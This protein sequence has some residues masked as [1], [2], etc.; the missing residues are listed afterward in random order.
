MQKNTNMN[1]RRL[2]AR[3]RSGFTLLETLIAT[4]IGALVLAGLMSV[5][6][7]VADRTTYAQHIA[8]SH[9]EALRSSRN[10]IAFLRNADAI[11]AIDTNHWRWVEVRGVNG[12]RTRF[13]H[14]NPIAGQRDGYMYMSNNLGSALVVARGMTEIM[15]PTGFSPSIFRI[16]ATN[17]LRISYRVVEPVMSQPGEN[18]DANIGAIVDTAVHLR[19][20][21]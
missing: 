14:V 5:F 17:T 12:V 15:T 1:D 21:Q 2:Q 20:A 8:W 6:V 19:N 9:N 11:T 4:G 10:L 18:R 13:V 7:W 16:T 3:G